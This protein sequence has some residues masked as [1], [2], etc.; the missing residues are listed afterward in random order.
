MLTTDVYRSFGERGL[1]RGASGF[2]ARPLMPVSFTARM[3]TRAASSSLI[4]SVREAGLYVPA[5][6]EKDTWM[7]SFLKDLAAVRDAAWLGVMRRGAARRGAA[8]AARDALTASV[9]LVARS[10]GAPFAAPLRPRPRR[11]WQL[12]TRRA[13]CAR[14]RAGRRVRRGGQDPHG[15][16]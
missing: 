9:A 7:T 5:A 6:K 1:A 11:A 14:A 12:L 16:D 8:A 3:A 10:A 4:P 15:A 13:C 2:A